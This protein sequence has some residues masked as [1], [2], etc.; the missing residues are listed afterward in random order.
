MPETKKFETNPLSIP[1]NRDAETLLDVSS[2]IFE[3]SRNN[4]KHISDTC[5][6][7]AIAQRS[8]VKLYLDKIP[9]SGSD[10]DIIANPERIVGLYELTSE[11]LRRNISLMIASYHD[12][13][14]VSVRRAALQNSLLDYCHRQKREAPQAAAQMIAWC[15][16]ETYYFPEK[17]AGYYGC[18]VEGRDILDSESSGIP[19]VRP[20]F[21]IQRQ[22][23]GVFIM[24]Y[25]NKRVCEKLAG[26]EQLLDRRI[27]L[28]PDLEAAPLVFEKLLQVANKEDI[29][30]QIKMWQRAPEVASAHLKS[31]KGIPEEHLRGDGIVVYVNHQDADKF[32]KQT[33]AIAGCNDGIFKGR[34][35]SRIPCRI[36]DGIAIGDEPQVPGYSLT[37]HRAKILEDAAT[38]VRQSGKQGVEAY[39]LFRAATRRISEEN[40]VNPRNIAFNQ[41]N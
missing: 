39:D 28:N 7:I 20:N 26:Q 14:D 1:P 40:G 15:T 31:L 4:A 33:L 37:S 22:L 29:S 10:T 38:I 8:S 19:D 36:V 41:E 5:A 16:G 23:G 18:E 27:Y 24:A 6:E 11:I 32:L 13:Q 25:T 2:D 12:N 30:L 35:T 9:R 34:H 21:K 17:E 3:A